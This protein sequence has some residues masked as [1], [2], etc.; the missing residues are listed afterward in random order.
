MRGFFSPF[1]TGDGMITGLQVHHDSLW[2]TV[3]FTLMK[4][5]VKGLHLDL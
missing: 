5:T 2:P 4:A 1:R 3:Y